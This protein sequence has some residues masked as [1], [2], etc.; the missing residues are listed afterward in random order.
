[1]KPAPT[2]PGSRQLYPDRGARSR[3]RG[4]VHQ[5]RHAPRQPTPTRAG[6]STPR[7]RRLGANPGATKD[8]QD[9]TLSFPSQRKACETK[10]RSRA[11]RLSASSPIRRGGG[12]TESVGANCSARSKTPTPALQRMLIRHMFQALDQFEVEKLGREVRCGQ[13][14]NTRRLSQWR[15]R[16]LW[17]LLE[18]GVT[19]RSR[20]SEGWRQEVAA[21]CRPERAPGIAVIFDRVM[22]PR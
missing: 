15:A 2:D 21:G 11:E 6:E 3:H 14:E 5:T 4:G 17:V 13:T 1:M 7:P 8:K 16:S 22:S 10:P 20:E 18:A 9:P 19:S 12:T